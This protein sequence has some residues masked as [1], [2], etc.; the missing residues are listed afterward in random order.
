MKTLSLAL[1]LLAAGLSAQ[2]LPNSVCCPKPAPTH[3]QKAMR[4]LQRAIV[5][6]AFMVSGIV[7]AARAD[8]FEGTPYFIAGTSFL[9]MGFTFSND[10]HRRKARQQPRPL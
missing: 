1:F 8:D 5:S 2:H 4:A 7:G 6:G 3:D 10:H 9:T